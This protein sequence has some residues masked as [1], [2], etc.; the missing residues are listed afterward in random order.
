M[1]AYEMKCNFDTNG[2][3]LHKQTRRF[4]SEQSPKDCFCM[5]AHACGQKGGHR[6]RKTILICFHCY[7]ASRG[8][9]LELIVAVGHCTYSKRFDV[10]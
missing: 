2:F 5:C 10:G 9:T 3:P 1:M 4:V 8:T 6:N 7:Q